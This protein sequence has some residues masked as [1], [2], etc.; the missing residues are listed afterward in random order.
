MDLK[1]MFTNIG[2]LALFLF[3]IMGFIITTQ[4]NNNV[5]VGLTSNDIMN[6]TYGDLESN[7]FASDAETTSDNFGKTPPT[8]QFGELEVT[9]IIAPT[10]FV[11]STIKGFWNIFIILPQA[12]LGVPPVVTTFIGS[13]LLVFLIIAIWAIWKGVIST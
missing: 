7:L 5:S 12:I 11:K 3:A 4:N 10:S 2:L 13:I 8:Q 6:D 9:S 1:K